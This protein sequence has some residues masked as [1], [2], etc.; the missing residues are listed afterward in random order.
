MVTFHHFT[1]PLWFTRD[2]G[3]EDAKSVD[4]FAR[5]CE[6]AGKA[7]GDLIAYACTINE[8]NIP[9][10]VTM[11]R[12]AVGVAGSGRREQALGE[13][14]R[15]CGGVPGRF[16]PY[17]S[18]DGHATAPNLIAAH[19]KGYEA[20]KPLVAGPVGITLVAQRLRGRGRGRRSARHGRSRDQRPVP[21]AGQRRR[22]R[23]RAD[24]YP[25]TLRP[26]TG[27]LPPPDGAERTQMGYEFYPE[28]LGGLRSGRPRGSAAAP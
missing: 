4:R 16:A 12:E 26:R 20:L 24:L 21:R 6:T 23:R 1:A 3:W 14:A 22:F 18:G 19:R 7:L 8:A 2:G 5:Y 25:R 27:V 10:M 17:L 13:A 9:I 28:A 11:I 15:L